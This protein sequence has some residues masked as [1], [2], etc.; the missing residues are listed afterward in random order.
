M[1]ISDRYADHNYVEHSYADHT[2]IG[3]DC[4]GHKYMGHRIGMRIKNAELQRR[5]MEDRLCRHGYGHACGNVC[6]GRVHGNVNGYVY[7]QLTRQEHEHGY[8]GIFAIT[9]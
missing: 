2:Y 6:G 7:G 9:I 8:N 3:H 5:Y 4:A 1:G